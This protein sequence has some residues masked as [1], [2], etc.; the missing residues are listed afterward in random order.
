MT[1]SPPN[2][3]INGQWMD[4]IPAANRGVAYGD[5]VFETIAYLR[6]RW[7]LWDR[8]MQRLE[9]GCRALRIPPPDSRTLHAEA[10]HARAAR[11]GG[12][13]KILLTRGGEGRGY[14]ATANADPLRMLSWHEYP[15][16]PPAYFRQ[17]VRVRYCRTPISIQPHLAGL[18]HCNRLDHVLARS[19]W[20]DTHIAEG[21]MHEPE[22]NIICG[23]RG[24]LFLVKND[25]LW[26][27]DLSRSGIAGCMRARVLETAKAFGLE[28]RITAIGRSDLESCEELFLSNSVFGIWPVRELQGQ[29]IPVGPITRRLQHSCAADWLPSTF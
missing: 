15:A 19:E 8:H 21:L 20:E 14:A 26:T 17:G 9:T 11:A 4:R 29:C 12:V 13:L 1:D 3:L 27:P 24:N 6:D 10:E 25:V 2:H 28:I 5:G 18:K 23:T 22:G 16:F 7:L